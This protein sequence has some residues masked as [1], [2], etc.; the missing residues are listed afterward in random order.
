[1]LTVNQPILVTGGSGTLGRGVVAR[2]LDTGHAVG[3]RTWEQFLADQVGH[4]TPAGAEGTTTEG[5]A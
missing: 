1:V 2:L 4:H 3:R 5:G